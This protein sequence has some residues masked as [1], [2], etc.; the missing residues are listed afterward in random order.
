MY[1]ILQGDAYHDEDVGAYTNYNVQVDAHGSRHISSPGGMPM[2]PPPPPPVAINQSRRPK[3]QI[4]EEGWQ[5]RDPEGN[6]HGPFMAAKMV[7][8]IDQKYFSLGLEVRKVTRRGS[9]AWTELKYV[10]ADIKREAA[11]TII[12]AA[13]S[14]GLNVNVNERGVPPAEVQGG[15]G[16]P[17]PPPP[18]HS[19]AF[20]EVRYARGGRGSR[21]G[22]AGGRGRV[23]DF[24][25]E[26]NDPYGGYGRGGG[27]DRGGGMRGGRGGRFDRGDGRGYR[28][29]RGERGRGGRYADRG[30]GR[31]DRGG[32]GRGGRGGGRGPSNDDIAAAAAVSKLFTGEVS[33]GTDQPMWRYIDPQG[34]MQGPFPAQDMESWYSEGYLANPALR[35]CGTE[36]KVAPPNL[37]PPEFFIPLGALIYWVRRGHKFTP[38]TVA[39]VVAKE[40]PA[41]L[42]KLKDGAERV[43]TPN[44]KKDEEEKEENDKDEEDTSTL[45]AQMAK[46]AVTNVLV[47]HGEQV[48]EEEEVKEGVANKESE[49]D[50]EEFVEAKGWNEEENDDVEEEEADKDEG[51]VSIATQGSSVGEN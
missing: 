8:W 45:A 27:E 9:G 5:Y 20:E 4:V 50:E 17:P 43:A 16:A 11:L 6:E 36:R 35:V 7:K 14:P 25:T 47:A 29:G 39:D 3:V 38:I 10:L 30:G 15:S 13:T 23:E 12:P 40:L 1:Y 26:Y 51:D 41:E 33:L 48:A 44:Q 19:P 2:T 18:P 24:D 46:M 32:R 31:G 34:N 49:E 37:P 22:R 21:G 42:Q 28:G